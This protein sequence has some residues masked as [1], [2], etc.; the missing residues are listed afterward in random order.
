MTK[1][2]SSQSI[3]KR[4]SPPLCEILREQEKSR[5]ASPAWRSPRDEKEFSSLP[6]S[7]FLVAC[8]QVS[9][10]Q[11]S[12]KAWADGGAKGKGWPSFVCAKCVFNKRK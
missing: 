4:G 12:A 7:A 3:S 11:F 1:E 9:L 2:Q 6:A 10:S 8:L 5:A